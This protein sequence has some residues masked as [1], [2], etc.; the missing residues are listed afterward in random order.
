[1]VHMCLP[2]ICVYIPPQ[3]A[4]QRLVLPPISIM[5]IV[6]SPPHAMDKLKGSKDIS[7]LAVGGTV[8][9]NDLLKGH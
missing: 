6:P 1:M 2:L 8:N 3:C 4:S 9:I 5:F 7:K